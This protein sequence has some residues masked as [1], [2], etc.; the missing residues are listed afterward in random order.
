[1]SP[2]IR[3]KREKFTLPSNYLL[4]ILSL[5]CIGACIVTFNTDLFN[6][7]LNAAAGYIVVPFQS[8]ITEIGGWLS[9]RS[10]ELS[11]IRDVLKENQELKAEVDELMM[12]NTLLQ[13][14]KYELNNLRE[15]YKLDEQ[16]SQYSKLGARIIAWN[17]GN[18][19]N[20]FTI[21]KGEKDGIQVDMNVMAGSG[22]V[23]RVVEVG[24]NWSK[25][26]SVIDDNSDVSGS[27]LST[28]DNL[29][30]SG[31]LELMKEGVIRFT[32]LIDSADKVV[33]GDK[34]VTSAISPKYLPGILIGYVSSI[35][36][37]ANNLT[38]SGTLTPAVDFEHLEEVL[39]ILELKQQV[40]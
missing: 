1:M 40:E 3:R 32:Q 12:E 25:V 36:R 29:I 6:G 2:V 11:Q 39:V 4:F 22:L 27:I 28:S 9:D 26:I 34:I 20:S 13:Q 5:L 35:S 31:D 17:G 24:P 30:V 14:D 19:Y 15:L 23:G 10:D 18:W 7:P 16:Y 37:D 21:D 38:K 8:G 33:S